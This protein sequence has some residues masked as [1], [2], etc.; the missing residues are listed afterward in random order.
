MWFI[1]I[2]TKIKTAKISAE[3]SGSQIAKICT[4]ENFPLYGMIMG[5]SVHNQRIERLWRDVYQGCL[6]LFS[7]YTTTFSLT[8]KRVDIV[9]IAVLLLII[10]SSI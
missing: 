9:A 1:G 10:L 6:G 4:R 3:G 2:D 5:R 7:V 8:S